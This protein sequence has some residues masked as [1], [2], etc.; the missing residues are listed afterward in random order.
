MG[1][2]GSIRCA[3]LSRGAVGR[4]LG[5]YSLGNSRLQCNISASLTVASTI[6]KDTANVFKEDQ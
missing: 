1:A 5:I 3:A 2:S 6:T 4:I